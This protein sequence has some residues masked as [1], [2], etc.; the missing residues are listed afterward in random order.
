[1][2]AESQ[3]SLE[4]ELL[5]FYDRNGFGPQTGARPKTVLVYTGCLL[6]PLPNIETRHVYLKYHD[7][8][9]LVIGYSVGRI[10][11]GR[12]SAWELGTGSFFQSPLLGVMNLIALST[13]LFLDRSSMWLAFRRGCVCRNLYPREIRQQVDNNTWH[14]IAELKS[15]LL[16][17]RHD[18]LPP[19]LR[20]IEFAA[21]ATV[22]V[23]IHAAMAIPAVIVR[24]CS[25]A[26]GAEGVV[27]ALC[28]WRSK[29]A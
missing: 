19:R 15:Q 4:R 23:A 6:V 13:G 9:H 10:G 16:D 3:S 7:L 5:A 24:F 18:R 11:E 21:Y 27:K 12:I 14:S 26:L 28:R 20:K 25:D 1:M 29:P 2:G 22:A 8:R 17:V